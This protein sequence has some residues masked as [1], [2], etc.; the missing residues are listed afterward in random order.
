M[1]KDQASLQV[2]PKHRSLI[3]VGAAQ[4]IVVAIKLKKGKAMGLDK[5]R[6][7]YLKL[8]SK[9]LFEL[10]ALLFFYVSEH[11]YGPA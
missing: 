6:S 11:W 5:I 7:E 4:I 3:N 2:F 1:K 8:G 9:L 10:T